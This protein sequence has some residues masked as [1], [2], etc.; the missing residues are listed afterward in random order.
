MNFYIYY[1]VAATHG[2]FNAMKSSAAIEHARGAP[3]TV[4]S[5]TLSNDGLEAFVKVLTED[6]T[7]DPG[8]ENAPFVIKKYVGLNDQFII[9]VDFYKSF[10]DGG[11]WQSKIIEPT[12]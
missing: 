6:G 12:G 9:D 7:F 1:H 3:G 5:V 2:S 8:W 11:N 4:L 10:S